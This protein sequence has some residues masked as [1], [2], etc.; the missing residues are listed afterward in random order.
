ML[1]VIGDL[2]LSDE[3]PWSYKVSK[4]IVDYILNNPLNNESNEV[5]FLGDLTESAFNSGQVFELLHS[6][7]LGLKFKRI[8][9]LIGN[10]DTKKNK[11]GQ[12]TLSYSFLKNEFFEN[13][14]IIN[15][16]TI[17]E[18]EGMTVFALPWKFDMKEYNNLK[19]FEDEYDLIVGHFMDN[20]VKIP[21]ETIDISY[22]KSKYV[23]LGHIHDK[24]HP[25]Y[26]GS[27]V[28]NSIE[29]AGLPRFIR[30]YTKEKGETLVKVP[31]IMD[32]HFVTF[33]KELPKV[34]THNPVWTI[35]N[36][37]DE[38]IAK[39]Q[40]GDIF[41]RKAVYDISM[42]KEAFAKLG[43]NLANK[44]GNKV[45]IQQLYEEWEKKVSY[46]KEV[47]DLAKSYFGE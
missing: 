17:I 13:V 26:C 10:H 42:D 38:A 24:N 47:M 20:T 12:T 46:P 22:L 36:C 32:Y 21:G 15:E 3:R 19:G 39:A 7:F 5:I 25:R 14:S 18:T 11:Q 9:I 16:P 33:P 8:Y 6:M 2:H 27:I 43:E 4:E 34:K 23:C 30:T 31:P 29:G 1:I 37:K 28:P 44:M 41:I 45:S 35:M 40:Y